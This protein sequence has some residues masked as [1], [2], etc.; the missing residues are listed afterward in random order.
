MMWLEI[1]MTFSAESVFVS[2][3][4]FPLLLCLFQCLNRQPLRYLRT[5]TCSFENQESVISRKRSC[6]CF[7]IRLNQRCHKFRWAYIHGD[8]KGYH[9]IHLGP[10]RKRAA[11]DLSKMRSVSSTT[12]NTRDE[13]SFLEPN[14]IF[15]LPLL[16]IHVWSERS[17]LNHL[18]FLLFLTIIDFFTPDDLWYITWTWSFLWSYTISMHLNTRTQSAALHAVNEVTDELDDETIKKTILPKARQVLEVNDD[19]Q[20]IGVCGKYWTCPHIKVSLVFCLR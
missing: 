15:V 18:L 16:T 14:R 13:T 4:F 20:V 19:V 17:P 5:S 2:L 11:K 10:H 7:W 9:Q 8:T 12:H 1:A 3:L 6:P